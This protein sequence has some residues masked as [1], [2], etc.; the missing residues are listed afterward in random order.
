VLFRGPAAADDHLAEALAGL[1]ADP[2]RL[3]EP[4]AVEN[5]RLDE[6]RSERRAAPGVVRLVVLNGDRLHGSGPPRGSL[7]TAAGAAITQ[8]IVGR[9]GH[10]AITCPGDLKIPKRWRAPGHPPA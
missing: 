5:P 3:V 6:Q 9:S 10:P 4:L 1:G 7:G 8:F 2:H